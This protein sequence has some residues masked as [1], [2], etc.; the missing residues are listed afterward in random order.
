MAALALLAGMAVTA[1]PAS[2]A[3]AGVFSASPKSGSTVS[4]AIVWEAGAKKPSAISRVDFLV[5]G[6]LRWTDRYAPFTYGGDGGRLDTRDLANGNHTLKVTAHETNGSRGSA[7]A[8]IVVRNTVDKTAPA[9]PSG[10]RVVSASTAGI[11]V[12]WS[13]ATDP[14]GIAG[15]RVFLDGVAAGDVTTTGRSFTGL[16]CGS[17]H[18]VAVDAV[19]GAGNRSARASIT[20]S[21]AACPAPPP[22]PSVVLP[23]A[24]LPEP[25]PPVPPAPEPPAPEPPAPVPPTPEPPP[26]GVASVFVAPGGSDAAACTAGAPCAS[27]DRAYRVADPGDVVQVAA[28]SYGSQTIAL[29]ATKTSSA[30][31]VIRPAAGAAVNLSYLRVYG[32]H[33]EVRGVTTNGWYLYP[34]AKDVTLRDV[35]SNE[36]AFIT[37]ADDVSIVGGEIRGVDSRDG[38]QVKVASSG[39]AEPRNLLIDGLFIHDITRVSDPTSHVECVQFTAGVG[40]TIRNSR[41]LD[42]GTQ[43]VFF[44]EGLGGQI[45]DVMI[46][47]NFFGKLSGYNTL[48]F[49]DGVS[50]MTA[51]YNSFAKAPR[52]GSGTGTSAITAYGNAGEL[53]S[54]GSG[55]TYR[56]NVWS[57]AACGTGDLKASPGFVNADGFDLRLAAGSAA[58]DRGDPANRPASD[59]FGTARP[60][61]GAPDAGAHELS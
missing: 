6:K 23:P 20:A 21:T 38:L 7:T 42:C 3:T 35:V 32:R 33:V 24:P 29:D 2:A 49:D 13:A 36:A 48:I 18:T 16:A 45:D 17:A 59:I 46:E 51:R 25:P 37:S 15:Y 53:A 22:P 19:D 60:K 8:K 43:G 1:G 5:D 12:A 34:G 52:L 61:G 9:A 4:G 11:D 27:L 56:Y 39:Y 26:A 14:S 30:D 41:F 31:V 50:R 54:C 58:I 55:V 57:G 28:G 10:L 40:V 44:K 47:N